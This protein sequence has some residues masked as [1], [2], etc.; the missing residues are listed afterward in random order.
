[1][2]TGWT[3]ERGVDMGRGSE[4]ASDRIRETHVVLDI[5]LRGAME[6][7]HVLEVLPGLG[8]FGGVYDGHGGTEAV[9]L[10][11]AS[12]HRF[13]A[14]SLQAGHPP[15]HAFREAYRSVEE[16][17][18]GVES[19][20]TAA[21]IFLR[22]DEMSFAHLGDARILLVG[23]QPISLTKDH[24]V[25]DSQERARILRAGGKIED[26][27]VLRGLRGLMPTRS[28][29]DAYFRPV[30]V[31]AVPEV[32]IRRLRPEDRFV[33]VACDGLFDVL[34]PLDVADLLLHSAG[35][36]E[37]AEILRDQVFLRGGT[38]NLTILVIE[39]KKG[40]GGE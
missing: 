19:G 8:L 37:G 11:G 7:R 38:D 39:F 30:G 12:L 1:M 9:D 24:R 36:K 4:E 27:Y 26:P 3:Y 32:G 23:P 20:A 28:F 14:T 29:G 25:S 33:V 5:G 13:F 22:G 15:V 6:D 34:E 2:T 18:K 35:A 31:T 21:T 17:L 10:V 16:E 40:G